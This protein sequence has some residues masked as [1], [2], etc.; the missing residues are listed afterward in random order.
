MRITNDEL[1]VL[2][3]I[4]GAERVIKLYGPLCKIELT[5]KQ[6]DIVLKEKNESSKRKEIKENG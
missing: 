6:L 2:L 1:K 4:E 3:K 5:S